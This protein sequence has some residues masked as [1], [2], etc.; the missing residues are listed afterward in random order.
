MRRISVGAFPRNGSPQGAE[1]RWHATTSERLGSLHLLRADD[2]ESEGA[3]ATRDCQSFTMLTLPIDIWVQR[4][5]VSAK[6]CPECNDVLRKV[7]TIQW[8]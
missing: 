6:E 1:E 4:Y 3:N 2:D 5:E 8:G 7:N